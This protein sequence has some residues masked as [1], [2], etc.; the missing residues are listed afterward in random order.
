VNAVFKAADNFAQLATIRKNNI[1]GAFAEL[2]VTSALTSK[3]GM[4]RVG[5]Q[6]SGKFSD[7]KRVV[8]DNVVVNKSGGV[9]LVNETKSG[10]AKLSANQA[11]FFEGGEAVT[12]VGKNA[13]DIGALGAK[14]SSAEVKTSITRVNVKVE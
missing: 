6:V 7:G 9:Q 2:K 4:S 3:Y 12:L 10:A 11:R 5:T 1:I 13:D 8:F 14:F